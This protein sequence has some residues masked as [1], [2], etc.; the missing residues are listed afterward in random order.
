MEPPRVTPLDLER[1]PRGVPQIQETACSGLALVL[2]HHGRL[3]HNRPRTTRRRVAVSP[4]AIP[5]ADLSRSLSR[6]LEV[7]RDRHLHDLGQSR[8]MLALPK[9]LQMR[10]SATTAFGW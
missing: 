3:G 6:F 5:A 9:R 4:R 8:L 10:A 7:G 1:V 2:R